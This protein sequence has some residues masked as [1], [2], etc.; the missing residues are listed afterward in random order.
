M[1]KII[2]QSRLLPQ[3]MLDAMASVQ[4]RQ[5]HDIREEVFRANYDKTGISTAAARK[6]L[7]LELDRLVPLEPSHAIIFGRE[8]SDQNR[9]ELAVVRKD[10]LANLTR[11]FPTIDALQLADDWTVKSPFR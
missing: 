10:Q 4:K 8:T 6:A 9:F 3:G 5:L 7:L 1:R 11:D 2:W